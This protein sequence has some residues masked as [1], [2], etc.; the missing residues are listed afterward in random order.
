MMEFS[1]LLEACD[2]ARNI[3]RAYHLAAGSDLFGHWVVEITYG[4]IGAKGRTK[5]VP[6]ADEAEARSYVQTCLKR[7]ESAPKRIGIGY[8]MIQTTGAW[9]AGSPSKG[10]L[11]NAREIDPTQ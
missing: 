3:H 5:V 10:N 8:K 9:N 1:I 6:V 7:R 11:P 2:P 4:R